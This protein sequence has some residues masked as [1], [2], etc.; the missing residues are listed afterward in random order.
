MYLTGST[1]S[2]YLPRIVVFSLMCSILVPFCYYTL[3]LYTWYTLIHI[4]VFFIF[5]KYK[6]MVLAHIISC[7]LFIILHLPNPG[8]K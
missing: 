5:F 8:N 2:T 3:I 4:K 1:M 7:Q 6:G